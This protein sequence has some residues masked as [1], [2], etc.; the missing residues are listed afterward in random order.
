MN[1]IRIVLIDDHAVL[2]D[3]LRSA[4]NNQ[5]DLQVV[6][7][8]GSGLDGLEIV[9]QM[10]PEVICLDLSMPGL[11]GMQVVE[12]LRGQSKAGVVILTMHDD[13]AYLRSA[14]AAGCIGYVLKASPIS[15]VFSAIRSAAAG[16]RY[17]DE[18]L[19]QHIQERSSNR[20]QVA[21]QA[22]RQGS[23]VELLSGREGEVLNFLAQGYTHQEIA[24]KINVSI[25]T[26]ETYR[27]RIKEKTGLRTRADFVRYGLEVR[28][29]Q[30]LG[31]SLDSDGEQKD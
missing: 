9:H 24:E 4:I 15:A 30:D 23:P 20:Q 31:K 21:A 12:A 16:H 22:A 7:E 19:G 6:G 29:Q 13:P 5:P 8:A 11:S 27:A 10:R 28:R 17:V 1:R 26:V 18:Q 2:R 25:K 14:L 3:G